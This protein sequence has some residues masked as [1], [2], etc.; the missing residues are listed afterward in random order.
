MTME[1][2]SY[3]TTSGPEESDEEGTFEVHDRD[4]PKEDVVEEVVVTEKQN[5]VIR[6]NENEVILFS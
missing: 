6:H 5:Y 1:A 4:V 2:T 3:K